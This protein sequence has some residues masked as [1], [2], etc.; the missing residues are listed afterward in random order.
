MY[1]RTFTQVYLHF[2]YAYWVH[3]VLDLAQFALIA[4]ECPY[5]ARHFDVAYIYDTKYQLH[6]CTWK[7]EVILIN[8]CVCNMFALFILMRTGRVVCKAKIA[9]IAIAI[10]SERSEPV[11]QFIMS[12]DVGVLNSRQR[13]WC[14]CNALRAM[15]IVCEGKLQ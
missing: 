6:L 7:V 11:K 1:V 15:P 13:C 14:A 12:G 4:P 3:R 5:H 8:V 9:Q 10:S 2:T